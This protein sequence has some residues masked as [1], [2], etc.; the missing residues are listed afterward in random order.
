MECYVGLGREVGVRPRL[1][2][3]KR[4]SGDVDGKEEVGDAST[5]GELVL[6]LGVSITFDIVQGVEGSNTKCRK[7]LVILHQNENT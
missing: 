3:W 7:R 2:K 4:A 5:K 6:G 1:N